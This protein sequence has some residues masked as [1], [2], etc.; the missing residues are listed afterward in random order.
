MKW[1]TM[2]LILVTY[3]T[4]FSQNSVQ[5][6][7]TLNFPPVIDYETFNIFDMEKDKQGNL[8]L[9]GGRSVAGIS[10]WITIK[11]ILSNWT[12]EWFVYFDVTGYENEGAIDLDI[13]STGNCYVAGIGVSDISG[14]SDYIV[15]KYNPS[16]KQEWAAAYDGA[17]SRADYVNDM[18]VDNLGNAY[19]TGFS[20][21]E[22]EFYSN[23]T[24][25]KFNSDGVMEW[26]ATHDNSTNFDE[27]GRGLVVDNSGNVYVACKTYTTSVE[28]LTIKYNSAGVEQWIRLAG[29]TTQNEWAQFIGLDNSGEVTVGGTAYLTNPPPYDPIGYYMIKYNPDGSYT[30]G[31]NTYNSSSTMRGMVVSPQGNVYVTGN[32]D[33]TSSQSRDFVTVK[34]NSS[35]NFQWVKRFNYAEIDRP[36]DIVI[37]GNENIFVTGYSTVP[38]VQA[39]AITVKYNS[40]GDSLWSNI[41]THQNFQNNVASRIILDEAGDMIVATYYYSVSTSGN[42]LIKLKSSGAYQWAYNYKGLSQPSS[43]KED[44]AGNIY[45][46]GFG[47]FNQSMWDYITMKCDS[48]GKIKWIRTYNGPADESDQ[49]ND[50]E[51]DDQGN[52]YVTGGSKGIGTDF[53]FA[54]IKYDSSGNEQWVV[55]YNAPAF[56]SDIASDI[57]VD[58]DGN[59]YV[60]GSSLNSNS[61]YDI[62]TI[63][64]NNLGQLQWV[65]RYNGSADGNDLAQGLEIDLSDN[66]FVVGTSDSTG[67]LYDYVTIKYNPSGNVEWTKRYNG[68]ANDGDI[69]SS[70]SLDNSGNVYVTGWSFGNTTNS[71]YATVKYNS[72]GVEQWAAR[73]DDP[74][75]SYDYANDIAVDEDGNVYVTGISQGMG[76]D[77][78]YTTVKYNSMGEQQ[79]AVPYNGQS[80]GSDIASHITLDHLGD[81]YVTGYSNNNIEYSTIK[82]NKQGVQQWEVNFDYLNYQDSPTDLLV[83]NSGN[84]VVAGYSSKAGEEWIWSIV[85]YNQP[86]FIPLDVKDE[87]TPPSEFVLYQNYPNPFNPTTKIRYTIPTVGTLLMKFVQLKIYDVLGN[88]VAKLVDEEKPAGSHEVNFDAKSLSSGVYYY[89]LKAGEFV[90]T[91]KLILMK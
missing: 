59:V 31:G 21:E 49:A 23:A 35:G 17:L 24:T 91:K 58:T 15:A 41:Y 47:G 53:D 67:S 81:I 34:F 66:V 52:V 73:W 10:E 78:D 25:V 40:S 33:V 12:V 11:I 13:D 61:T 79:W 22:S 90:Q 63:K 69:A 14:H 72:S 5:Q 55:R 60:S 43:I 62:A 8:Y 86:G 27:E 51:L 87:I 19:L 50:I 48:S 76:T 85:K 4:I 77:N 80:N 20:R 30:G 84:V 56:D 37:D 44:S 45:I 54:T 70:M 68:S 42:E 32:P 9:L 28:F 29:S 65:K 71:D 26:K 46:T 3:S 36:T 6:D 7:W 64:Y 57:S 83:D 16:G 1:F 82:Y 39:Y 89:R 18:F 38:S 74:A 2:C 88:E 75:S